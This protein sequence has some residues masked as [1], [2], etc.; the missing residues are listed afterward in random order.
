[1]LLSSRPIQQPDTYSFGASDSLMVT[2]FFMGMGIEKYPKDYGMGDGT[3]YR[4]NNLVK[5]QSIKKK[6]DVHVIE[7]FHSQR[8]Q[9]LWIWSL[10]VNE[11][12]D[13]DLPKLEEVNKNVESQRLYQKW[14]NTWVEIANAQDGEVEAAIK[15]ITKM[16]LKAE[17]ITIKENVEKGIKLRVVYLEDTT[18]PRALGR[19]YSN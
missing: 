10:D 12:W 2:K 11:F 14:E 17:E 19:V 4:G 8:K 1:M 13:N 15:K 9:I 6:Q 7:V 3:F 5:T 18:D 16:G